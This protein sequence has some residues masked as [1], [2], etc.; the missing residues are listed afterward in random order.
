MPYQHSHNSA[1]TLCKYITSDR[2]VLGSRWGEIEV[3]QIE[4][5]RV[6][7]EGAGEHDLGR[8]THPSATTRPVTVVTPKEIYV[9][10]AGYGSQQREKDQ[11]VH[12][13]AFLYVCPSYNLRKR[14]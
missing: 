11:G 10:L 13:G 3:N 12:H 7:R 1:S 8:E 9:L 5:L 2:P 6:C 14:E 4:R